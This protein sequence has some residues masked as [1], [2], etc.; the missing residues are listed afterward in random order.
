MRGRTVERVELSK[1]RSSR[2]TGRLL[3]FLPVG[4][5]LLLLVLALVSWIPAQNGTLLVETFSSG[6]YT[7]SVQ[8]HP[9]VTVGSVTKVSPF[10]LS[11]PQGEY[12]VV[13]GPVAWYA[14]PDSRSVPLV[15]GK[16]AFAV[17]YY[18]PLVRVI[19]VTP[20]GFNATSVTAK[21]S[22]TPVVWVNTGS[23]AI[24]IQID[25]VG[26]VSLAPSA[27]YTAVFASTGTFGYSIYNTAFSGSVQA[28]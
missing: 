13:F 16:T 17:A 5:L 8:I 1:K 14:T 22:V 12:N 21:H 3:F 26:R 19:A 10:N 7:P 2:R 18:S 24:V 15:G 23:A 25:G 28:E 4:L 11:L 9:S 27:N 6:R 20:D